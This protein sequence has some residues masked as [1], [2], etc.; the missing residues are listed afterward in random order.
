MSKIEP[1]LNRQ[2]KTAL[3]YDRVNTAYGGAEQV[4]M[5][6]HQL[7]P[8]AP[9]YTSVYAQ[10]KAVWAKNFQIK[11]SFLQNLIMPP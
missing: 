2:I 3:V 9:L 10:K 8:Q 7:F 5:A 6:L 11:T 1:I 4:M